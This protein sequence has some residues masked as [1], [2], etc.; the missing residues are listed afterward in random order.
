MLALHST[1]IIALSVLLSLATAQSC[2]CPDMYSRFDDKVDCYCCPGTFYLTT[3]EA[4][5][6]RNY[7]DA[8]C[9]VEVYDPNPFTFG[10]A[11]SSEIGGDQFTFGGGDDDEQTSSGD[12]FTFGEN[13]TSTESGNGFTF[14]ENPTSTE[15]GNPFTFGENPTTTT[16]TATSIQARDVRVLGREAAPLVTA[17]AQP[18]RRNGDQCLTQIPLTASDYS[19]QAVAASSLRTSSTT[20]V[21]SSVTNNVAP[22]TGAA[23][24]GGVVAVGMAAAV[25][26]AA[27]L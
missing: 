1:P 5:A 20:D 23:H 16:I 18:R 11:E 27:I 26:A 3:D 6:A 14:G 13:P 12:P 8:F 2:D 10:G 17:A 9:C 19:S 15:S 25:A 24:V 22:P 4:V 7:T 21:V